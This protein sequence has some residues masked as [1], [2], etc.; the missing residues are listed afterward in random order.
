MRF[1]DEILTSARPVIPSNGLVS[2]ITDAGHQA[3][4]ARPPERPAFAKA[5]RGLAE[6]RS[7]EAEAGHG[8]PA[9]DGDGGSGGAK[10]PGLKDDAL[11]N[12]R[13][14]ALLV[15][16]AVVPALAQD[17]SHDQNRD[18]WQKVDEIFAAMG[19]K[20][21]AVVGDIGAGGGYFT[22][23][24][25]RAVG[26]TGRVYAV[27]VGADAIRRLGTRVTSEGLKNVEVVHGAASDPKLPP[28]TLDAALIVNAY[29][30][31]NEHKAML[32]ALKAAL[33]PDGRLV[34]VEPISGSRR[35][36][37]RNDQTRNHEIGIGFVMQDA[38]DAGF[39][40]V[41]AQDP[42]T[43][44]ADAHGDEEWLLVLAPS[45]ASKPASAEIDD[46][47]SPALRIAPEDFK[48][49]APKRCPHPRC[50]RSLTAIAGV[51]CQA[52]CS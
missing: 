13:I 22:S 43:K 26:D 24:L 15:V 37:A 7:A 27:D 38:R 46:W 9:S 25:S 28:A 12:I 52:R 35:S 47:K 17:S 21:G 23:R 39:V 6:A 30:E 51:I 16:L 29:H 40:E 50:P 42:F 34:I 10:P 19:V 44:R 41:Q 49:L 11:T 31:M 5:A 33:K 14:A 45:A 4:M 32:T 2:G 8:A 48:K 1:P 36:S 18:K 20:P 3:R